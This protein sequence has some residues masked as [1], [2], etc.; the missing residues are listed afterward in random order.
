[1]IFR[2]KIKRTFSMKE[3]A[4]TIFSNYSKILK[5]FERFWRSAIPSMQRLLNKDDK[6]KREIF[7]IIESSVPVNHD[8][9]PL[10]GVS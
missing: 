6:R 7:K 8:S 2:I 10:T 1:M 4:I 5:D 3:V 9:S